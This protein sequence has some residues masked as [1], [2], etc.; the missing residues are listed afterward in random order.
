MNQSRSEALTPRQMNGVISLFHRFRFEAD[1]S[2]LNEQEQEFYNSLCRQAE[3][4]YEKCGH[5]PEFELCEL[6]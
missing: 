6:D 5:Y 3:E 4:V 2:R 1:T